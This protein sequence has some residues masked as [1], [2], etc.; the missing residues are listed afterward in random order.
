MPGGPDI[1][2]IDGTGLLEASQKSFLGAP[3]LVVDGEDHTFLFGVI[4][5][6]LRLR[7][8]SGI[9]Q[10]VFVIGEEA[11]QITTDANIKKLSL[12]SSNSVSRLC[13]IPMFMFLICVPALHH[14]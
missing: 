2:L 3:L 13:M 6:L 5:D 8:K 1:F 9:N 4:R 12:S 7:Q 14:W 10:G 11:H